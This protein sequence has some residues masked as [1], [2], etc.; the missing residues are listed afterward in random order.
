VNPTLKLEPLD[1]PL[2]FGQSNMKGFAGEEEQDLVVQVASH[3]P[4]NFR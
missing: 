1:L 3:S 4:P 2:S